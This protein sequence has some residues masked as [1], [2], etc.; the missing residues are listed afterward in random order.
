MHSSATVFNLSKFNELKQALCSNDSPAASANKPFYVIVVSRISGNPMS[1]LDIV[2]LTAALEKIINGVSID[3]VA[4]TDV[5]LNEA[6]SD[7]PNFHRTTVTTLENNPL[8]R[9]KRSDALLVSA[10][11]HQ[12][13]SDYSQAYEVVKRQ[14]S[15]PMVEPQSPGIVVFNESFFHGANGTGDG[16]AH[17]MPI[18]RAQK[19]GA[20][21]SGIAKC[22][23]WACNST[24][25]ER[26]SDP[27]KISS[28]KR[29]FDSVREKE[30]AK[31]ATTSRC[32]YNYGKIEQTDFTKPVYI[33]R[34]MTE[35]WNNG[36]QLAKYL[37]STYCNENDVLIKSGNVVYEFGNWKTNKV[38]E[39]SLASI[40]LEN[41]TTMICKDYSYQM[42]HNKKIKMQPSN[43]RIIC[44]RQNLI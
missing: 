42:N 21:L 37:K 8:E 29:N 23:I 3:F 26:S 11:L 41:F 18:A 43:F 33:M 44:K 19:I 9:Y 22:M 35:F 10:N 20:S 34:N 14:C 36:V 27:G 25:V 16:N 13:R 7:V 15:T 6:R 24:T 5:A 17:V 1:S 31:K 2:L 40:F 39:S 38:N 4:A 32:S 28:L 12:V 30:E